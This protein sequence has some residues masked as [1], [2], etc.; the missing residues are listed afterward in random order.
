[1]V[2]LPGQSRSAGRRGAIGRSGS[3]YSGCSLSLLAVAEG[4]V[5][6]VPARP[7]AT[8]KPLTLQKSG[9]RGDFS[10]GTPENLTRVEISGY[11]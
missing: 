3:N 9:F 8:A 2:G 1:M 10:R 6:S 7:A 5:V 4:H 11:V